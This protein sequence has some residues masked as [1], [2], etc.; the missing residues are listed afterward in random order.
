MCIIRAS[1]F[2]HYVRL[3]KRCIISIEMTIVLRI[4]IHDSQDSLIIIIFQETFNKF[5]CRSRLFSQD[6][7]FHNLDLYYLFINTT[8]VIFFSIY[9]LPICRNY[10]GKIHDSIRVV[11]KPH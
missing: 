2:Y 9:F 1:I 7:Y 10:N 11:R 6:T 4:V 3:F 5:P 8:Y